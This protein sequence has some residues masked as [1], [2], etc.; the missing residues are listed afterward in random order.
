MLLAV[1]KAHSK[2]N[3]EAL[4]QKVE[5]TYNETVAGV[6]PLSEDLVQLASEGV[7]CVKYPE[8]MISQ[9]FNNVAQK[10]MAD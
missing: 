2:L 5:Q 4:R 9:E 1:N 6:F 3:L 7:F 8:H 10:I